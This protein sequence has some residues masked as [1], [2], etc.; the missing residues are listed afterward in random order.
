MNYWLALNNSQWAPT[1]LNSQVE[2][3]MMLNIAKLS[4]KGV[5]EVKII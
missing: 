5:D 4:N 1:S 3:K 2:E